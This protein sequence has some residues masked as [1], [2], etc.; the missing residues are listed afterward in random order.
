MAVRETVTTLA[1]IAVMLPF[2]VV[3][4]LLDLLGTHKT[5]EEYV[6]EEL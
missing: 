2:I 4:E 5:D 6:Y 1:Y 3:C